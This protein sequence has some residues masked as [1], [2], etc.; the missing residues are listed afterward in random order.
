MMRVLAGGG[1]MGQI[2]LSSPEHRLG[3]LA[4]FSRCR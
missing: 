3:D 4:Q 1:A 2:V